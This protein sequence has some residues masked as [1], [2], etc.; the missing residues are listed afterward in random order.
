MKGEERLTK[1]VQFTLVYDEGRTQTDHFLVIKVRPNELGFSRYGVSV[2]KHVGKAVV[3]NRIK[4]ILREILRLTPLSP[5]WD[6]IFI[7]RSPSAG[8]DYSQLNESVIDLLSRSGL[9]AK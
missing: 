8:S 1:P 9:K 3:R 7:A 6:I 4:R 5:G 2:S